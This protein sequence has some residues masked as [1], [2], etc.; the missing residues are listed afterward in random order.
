M[1]QVKAKLAK[2]AFALNMA[3]TDAVRPSQP[4]PATSV[5]QVLKG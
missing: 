3:R 1:E 5:P 4:S 2:T